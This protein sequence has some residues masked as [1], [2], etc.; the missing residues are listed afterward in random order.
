[1]EDPDNKRSQKTYVV[2]PRRKNLLAWAKGIT[3]LEEAKQLAAEA[4]RCGIQ[5]IILDEGDQEIEF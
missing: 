3:S 2:R 5:V 1:M 4:R